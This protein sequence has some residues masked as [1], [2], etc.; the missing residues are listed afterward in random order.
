MNKQSYVDINPEQL[1]AFSKSPTEGPLFM[2]NLIKYKN[3]VPETGRSGKE[4]YKE[5]MRQATPF[6]LKANADVLFY[7]SPMHLL[8]GPEDET[9]WD[10]VL[11]V[12]Y[13]SVN[14]FM[15]M[16]KTK[17]YPAQ[18]RNQALTDSRLIHCTS[19]GIKST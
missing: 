11:L 14:D 15:A 9:L 13:N 16:I 8:I 2:L 17:G 12:K 5:Y 7:G 19:H 10:D 4:S 6:F 3:I 1:S 18:L